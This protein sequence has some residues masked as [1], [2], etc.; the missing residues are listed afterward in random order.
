MAWK[1]YGCTGDVGEPLYDPLFCPLYMLLGAWPKR[2]DC[3]NGCDGPCKASADDGRECSIVIVLGD[4][5]GGDSTSAIR[6]AVVIDL[7]QARRQV[8]A[9]GR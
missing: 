9:Y 5:R 8:S 7:R 6:S 2:G 3:E 4:W 1:A